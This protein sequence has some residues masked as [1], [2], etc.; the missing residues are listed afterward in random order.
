MVNIDIPPN[1]IWA[2]VPAKLIRKKDSFFMQ[3]TINKNKKKFFIL[4][5]NDLGDVLLTTPLLYALREN[6]KDS[7]IFIGIGEWAIPLLKNNPNID[8]IIRCNAPW[9]NKQNCNYPANSIK[10]FLQGLLYVLFSNESRFIAFN[11]SRT[12]LIF[13]EVGKDLGL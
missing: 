12:E 3:R 2:G 13:L 7:K 4:R 9:H 5:N 11:I 1:E 10:T 8:G 6:F